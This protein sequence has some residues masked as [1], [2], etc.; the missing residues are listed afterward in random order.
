M[1]PLYKSL[2][3]NMSQKTILFRQIMRHTSSCNFT[4]KWIAHLSLPQFRPNIRNS[5]IG[6]TFVFRT[7]LRIIKLETKSLWQETVHALDMALFGI[8]LLHF[9]LILE[10]SLLLHLL[11]LGLTMFTIISQGFSKTCIPLP[12]MCNSKNPSN[13]SFFIFSS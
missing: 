2:Q 4:K 6:W 9:N 8:I 13:Q 10:P 3:F 11:S 5:Y 1:F 7:T 12:C